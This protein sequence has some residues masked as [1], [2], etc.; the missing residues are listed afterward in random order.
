MKISHRQL[1][2]MYELLSRITIHPHVGE[3]GLKTITDLLNEIR[4]QQSTVLFEF[5]DPEQFYKDH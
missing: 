5:L 3:R 2:D 1:L 4:N